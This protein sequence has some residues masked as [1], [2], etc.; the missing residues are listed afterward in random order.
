MVQFLYNILV[1]LHPLYLDNTDSIELDVHTS[2]IISPHTGLRYKNSKNESIQIGLKIAEKAN[3]IEK[4]G[5]FVDF[6][7]VKRM[8]KENNKYT[9]EMLW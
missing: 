6:Y 1:V 5:P 9:G 8:I 2:L 4:M 7:G 3:A